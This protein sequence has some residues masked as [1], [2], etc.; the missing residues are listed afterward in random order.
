M[1]T[2]AVL[3]AKRVSVAVPVRL[4]VRDPMVWATTRDELAKK[5]ARMYGTISMQ[6]PLSTRT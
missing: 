4:A 6:K 2:E 5:P 1:V 3:V